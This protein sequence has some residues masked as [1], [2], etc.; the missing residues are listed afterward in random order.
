[1][2]YLAWTCFAVVN[3]LIFKCFPFVCADHRKAVNLFKWRDF[4]GWRMI[5]LTIVTVLVHNSVIISLNDL[6]H[7]LLLTTS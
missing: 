1:M 5:I 4:I 6:V 7:S 2:K 3:L